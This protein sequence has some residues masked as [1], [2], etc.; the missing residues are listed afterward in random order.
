MNTKLRGWLSRLFVKDYNCIVCG[1]ELAAPG[2]YRLCSP[3]YVLMEVIGERACLKCGKMLFA[4]EQYCLDCQNNERSFD[5]ALAPFAYSGSAA[6]LV[7]RLKFSRQRYLADA[8]NLLRSGGK[9]FFEIGEN[10][11]EAVA[12]M[13]SDYGFADVKVEKDFAGHDRY[14]S[15][16][17]Q[18]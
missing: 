1:R 5:R 15:A 3:C 11:G 8:M 6:I 17:Q 10:Q 12:R 2:R 13:M 4:E 9:I 18:G 7:R 14:A 16:T